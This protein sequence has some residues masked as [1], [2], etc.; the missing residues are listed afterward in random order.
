M[1]YLKNRMLRTACMAVLFLAFLPGARARDRCPDPVAWDNQRYIAI[2]SDLHFGL[3]KRPDGTWFPQEDFR[4]SKALHGFL[5]TVSA[6]GQDTVDLVVA[7]DMLE[8]W[9]PPVDLLCAKR[10]ADQGCTPAEFAKLT[11]RI[12]ANHAADL[13]AIGAFADRGNNRVFIV[14]GNHDAALLLPD[15]WIAVRAAMKSTRNRVERVDSGIWVSSDGRVVVE[16]GHQIGQDV[17]R[18][19]AWPNIMSTGGDEKVVARPWGELF[20]Q[21]IFNDQEDEYSVIDNLSPEA[22]GV[23]YRIA[24]RGLVLS[25]V[26]IARFLA[27]NLFETSLMQKEGVLGGDNATIVWNETVGRQLGHRLFA[28]ALNEK[29]PFRETLL[30]NNEDAASLRV[31]LDRYAADPARLSA[32]EVETLCT[33]MALRTSV[34]KSCRDDTMGA[35]MQGLFRTKRSVMTDHLAMRQEEPRLRRMRLFVYSHTHQL[36]E[37][38]PVQATELSEVLVFNTGAFQR[39][40]DESGFL[41]R[42]SQ[43]NV[44]PAE[45]LRILSVEELAPCYTAVLVGPGSVEPRGRTVRWLMG[46]NDEGRFVGVGDPACD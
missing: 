4:W 25:V 11:R 29:D 31:E 20:V 36:E 17:N 19:D 16:H 24:D 27:F 22:T 40:V 30:A 41:A 37:Q 43:R 45:A 8:L 14:P 12:V 28:D 39:V 2:I 34:S 15:S 18:Y 35:V 5:D 7:G 6:C 38:W 1:V 13:E 3:G 32:A 10:P 23:R 9:Q 33:Q 46:E 26:D 21:R 42:A 44:T